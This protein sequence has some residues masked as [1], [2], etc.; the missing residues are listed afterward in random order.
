[1]PPGTAPLR[2][3]SLPRRARPP[4]PRRAHPCGCGPRPRRQD[5][6]LAVADLAAAGVGEDDLDRA[7]HVL[8]G[9]HDV[10]PEL[11]P[12]V[13]HLRR[14]AVV[15][16]DAGLA[17]G[18][19]HVGDRHAR[20]ADRVQL[21]ADRLERLV[22]DVGLD[23]LHGQSPPSTV[24]GV[25]GRDGERSGPAGGDWEPGRRAASR[26][27]RAGTAPGSPTCRAR[28]CRGPRAPAGRVTRRPIV[29][30]QT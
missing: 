22:A 21:G 16:D 25:V 24:A 9:H 11:R 30:L 1:M 14:A 13:E 27:S 20:Q 18:A 12:E 2:P 8:V 5:E 4:R 15:L 26:R 23:L 7:L 19:E 10:E 6:D 28:G 3:W 29:F 17:A